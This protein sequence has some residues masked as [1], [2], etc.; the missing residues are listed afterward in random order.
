[1]REESSKFEQSLSTPTL[2]VFSIARLVIF[3]CP[4]DIIV[5]VHS[6]AYIKGPKLPRPIVDCCRQPRL[7]GKIFAYVC[8]L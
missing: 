2:E 6:A 7:M 8:R 5:L 4:T 1:M 3:A